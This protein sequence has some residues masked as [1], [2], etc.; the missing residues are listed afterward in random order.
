MV[1]TF[2][3]HSVIQEAGSWIAD[4]AEGIGDVT[5]KK[6]ASI[7][8]QSVVRGDC[9]SIVIGPYSNVQDH[10]TLHTDL[11]YELRIGE[12]VTIGHRCII[13]GCVI[14]DHCMI[15]MGAIIMN[16]AHVEKN[17]IIGAGAVVLE[18][19]RIPANSIAVGSPAKVIKTL[20]PKQHEHILWNAAHYVKLAHRHQEEA[21]C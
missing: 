20:T 2:E 18:G 1:K 14:E 19:M 17:C 10:C 21:S 15:G 7:W 9:G 5:L 11:H 8:Y 12:S 4:S 16:G 3:D 6:D 13:H